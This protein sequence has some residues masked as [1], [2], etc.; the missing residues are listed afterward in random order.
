MSGRSYVLDEAVRVGLRCFF[1]KSTE[2]PTR[3]WDYKVG[4]TGKRGT[5]RRRLCAD[6]AAEHKPN[7]RGPYHGR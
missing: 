5:Y 4:V 6:C 3:L 7:I 1:C 2:K